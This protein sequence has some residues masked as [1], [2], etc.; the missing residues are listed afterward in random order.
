MASTAAPTEELL[1]KLQTAMV[2]F[3]D[4]AAVLSRTASETLASAAASGS[5]GEPEAC[6][7]SVRQLAA[8]ITYS[9]NTIRNM[10]C[11]GQLV[12][13]KHFYKRGRC[14]IFSWPAMRAWVEEQSTQPEDVEPLP[15]VRNRRN[16]A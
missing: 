2:A 15:L 16:G 4:L 1:R 6:Y 10:I 11:D 5:S 8:R 14:V 12:E 7:L 3:G 9:E 13:G